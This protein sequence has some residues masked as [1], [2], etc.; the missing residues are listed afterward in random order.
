MFDLTIKERL[1][2]TSGLMIGASVAY[3]GCGTNVIGFCIGVIIHQVVDGLIAYYRF[4]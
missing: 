4:G 1:I 3:F 2:I